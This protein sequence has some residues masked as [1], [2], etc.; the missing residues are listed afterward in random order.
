MV[1]QNLLD[2]VHEKLM[3]GVIIEVG[4]QRK[5]D[6]RHADPE[7]QAAAEAHRQ[8]TTTAHVQHAGDEKDREENPRKL[9]RHRPFQQRGDH[10]ITWP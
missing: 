1:Q 10:D 2:A 3:L 6:D 8:P 5:I 7:H 9:P 4:M